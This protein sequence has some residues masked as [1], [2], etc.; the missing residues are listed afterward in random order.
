MTWRKRS[1]LLSRAR[2]ITI[3]ATPVLNA[4]QWLLAPISRRRILGCNWTP[5]TSRSV[6]S[7][8]NDHLLDKRSASFR[9]LPNSMRDRDSCR[10]VQECP[11][12][13]SDFPENEEYALPFPSNLKTDVVRQP[14]GR[15][16][17]R[18]AAAHS[19]QVD[20]SRHKAATFSNTQVAM[21]S[22]AIDSSTEL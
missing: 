2:G 11:V 6:R 14:V 10:T 1:T 8:T 13:P 4:P 17:C 20:V 22:S 5:A 18:G 3:P 9:Y 16:S 19:A 12:Y 15:D 21:D 7:L